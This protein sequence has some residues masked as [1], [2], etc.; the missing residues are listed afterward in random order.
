VT[1][2]EFRYDDAVYVLGAL[3]DER[4][5]DFEAHLVTCASCRARVVEVAPTAALLADLTAVDF[6]AG[7]GPA[8]PMPDTLLP[9]LLRRA[10]RERSRRRLVSASIASVAAACLVALAVVLWPTSSAPPPKGVALSAV[11]PSP[12][13]ATAVLVS[14]HWG[15]QIG[16]RCKY[17][18]GVDENIP[19]DLQVVDTSGK[20]H[21]AGSWTLVPGHEI[22]FTGGTDVP[23]QRIAKVLITL[24]DGTPILQLVV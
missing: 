6:D 12:V 15:T 16:L 8:G 2:D 13:S 10:H 4:R 1:D 11:V 19:Y 3:D 23:R 24:T 5:A 17:S 7:P 22:S 14:K 21:D 9:G 20:W 18:Q